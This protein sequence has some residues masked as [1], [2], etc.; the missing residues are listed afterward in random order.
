MLHLVGGKD[1]FAIAWA[2]RLLNKAFFPPLSAFAVE[3]D[4][5]AM[6][7]AVL[8]N[9]F[10]PNGNIEMTMVGPGILT[11][12]VV[13]GLVDYCFSQNNVSRV[14]CKTKRANKLVQSLLPRAGFVFESIQKRYFGATK[15][16]DAVVFVLHRNNLPK[17]MIAK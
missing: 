14:T 5:G 10:Y 7:G 17:W 16:D 9:D 3:D 11:G 2:S 4:R 15:D 13:R 6:R 12:R 8:F 1:E